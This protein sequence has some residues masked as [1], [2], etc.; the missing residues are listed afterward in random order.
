MYEL[1]FRVDA[2]GWQTV[3]DAVSLSWAGQPGLTLQPGGFGTWTGSLLVGNGIWTVELMADG[4]TDG[5]VREVDL[6]WPVS[7]DGEPSTSAS[8][9]PRRCVPAVRIRTTRA[10]RRLPGQ[11][12]VRS[13]RRRGCTEPEAVNFDASAFFDD[14]SCQFNP[15]ND[16][17]QDL[18]G[19]GFVGVSDILD[20]LTYFGN[21][22]D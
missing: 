3:P 11:C 18:T 20:L 21:L 17:P 5:L 4:A 12:A 7:W 1:E 14:G 10:S 15:G 13:R 22:C 2:T 19:D 8:A 6:T 16:C 9:R